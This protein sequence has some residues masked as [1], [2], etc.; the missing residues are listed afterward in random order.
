MSEFIAQELE[1]QRM[2]ADRL[3]NKLLELA[4]RSGYTAKERAGTLIVTRRD[5]STATRLLSDNSRPPSMSRGDWLNALA[6]E[7]VLLD[8]AHI[9][10]QL[11]TARTLI[12]SAR[13]QWEK[14]NE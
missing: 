10:E 5:G 3:S 6:I 4:L 2:R 11:E 13:K 8:A 9:E 7:Q 12:D 14:R 1:Y